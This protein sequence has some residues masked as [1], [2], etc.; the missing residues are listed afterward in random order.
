VLQNGHATRSRAPLIAVL[1]ANAISLLGNV[2]IEVIGLRG[3]LL[4]FAIGNAIIALIIAIVP[5]G[6]SLEQLAAAHGEVP[7]EQASDLGGRSHRCRYR[8]R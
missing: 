1:A 5:A 7:K 6:R 3:A 2:L 4:A 8:N